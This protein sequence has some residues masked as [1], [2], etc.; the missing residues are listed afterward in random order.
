MTNKTIYNVTV[1]R[2]RELLRETNTS[3]NRYA[4]ILQV[5]QPTVSNK[6]SGIVKFTA[7]D[8][9]QTSVAF[10]VST[11]YLYGLTDEPDTSTSES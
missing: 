11:D 5:A 2:V 1:E 9:R 4:A 7:K 3:Q 6:L 10:G 8:I